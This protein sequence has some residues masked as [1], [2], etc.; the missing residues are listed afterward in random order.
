MSDNPI[1][2]T[3]DNHPSTPK[4]F[5]MDIFGENIDMWPTIE[6]LLE[7]ARAN[8]APRGEDWHEDNFYRIDAGDWDAGDILFCYWKSE[9]LS[10]GDYWLVY[11]VGLELGK[12][13]RLLVTFPYPKSWTV[14][15]DTVKFWYSFDKNGSEWY[16]ETF[17]GMIN[18]DE[19][20]DL[21][22]D[23]FSIFINWA[24]NTVE[25]K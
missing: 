7:S 1:I 16:S 17:Y 6:E 15:G 18:I 4:E 11:V 22:K 12:A 14:A 3:K 25:I 21:H 9:K 2:Y 19:L 23:K 8:F 20:K 13:G 10:V 5:M 24:D